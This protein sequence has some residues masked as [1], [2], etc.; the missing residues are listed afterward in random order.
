VGPEALEGDEKALAAGL[1]EAK[2][3]IIGLRSRDRRVIAVDG[4]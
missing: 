1:A 2:F 4:N 3:L